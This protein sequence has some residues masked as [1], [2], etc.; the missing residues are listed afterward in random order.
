MPIDINGSPSPKAH[1]KTLMKI[2]YDFCTA[3]ADIADNSISAE[4]SNIR[5]FFSSWYDSAII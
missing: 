3:V 4:C 1:I 2:G 5:I